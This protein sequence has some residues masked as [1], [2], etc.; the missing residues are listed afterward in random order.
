MQ[1]TVFVTHAN[2]VN[3]EALPVQKVMAIAMHQQRGYCLGG[4]DYWLQAYPK[5]GGL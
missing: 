3:G 5:G 1:Q 2:G 4:I